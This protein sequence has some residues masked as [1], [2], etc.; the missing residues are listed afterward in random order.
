MAEWLSRRKHEDW[1]DE[2]AKKRIRATPDE[3]TE[4]G[5]HRPRRQRFYYDRSNFF[6]TINLHFLEGTPADRLQSIR[7]GR[8]RKIA[9]Y[10]ITSTFLPD[11]H[12]DDV[13]LTADNHRL[14]ITCDRAFREFAAL[15]HCPGLR[16]DPLAISLILTDEPTRT[17]V[18]YCAL[19]AYHRKEPPTL[20]R[21]YV[22]RVW[23]IS[24]SVWRITGRYKTAGGALKGGLQLYSHYVAQRIQPKEAAE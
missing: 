23:D 1:I 21:A 8:L 3:L 2:L 14:H 22:A 24:G 10:P 4:A 5:V 16:E 17:E 11:L 13:E 20:E 9:D 18:Y 15:F 19:F 12:P 6:R 7:A